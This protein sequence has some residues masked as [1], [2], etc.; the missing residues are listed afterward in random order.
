MLLPALVVPTSLVTLDNAN[1]VLIND[2]VYST[3]SANDLL[4]ATWSDST[5]L[6]TKSELTSKN[7]QTQQS[8]IPV[9]YLSSTST[10]D[11]FGLMHERT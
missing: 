10:T 1:D 6:A 5:S 11:V 3:F 7:K 8:T 4:C 2:I 9:I